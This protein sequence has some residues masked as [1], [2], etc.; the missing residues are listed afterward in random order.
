MRCAVMAGGG[1]VSAVEWLGMADRPV[2][3]CPGTGV[4]GV[5]C[6]STAFVCGAESL[7]VRPYFGCGAHVP[8]CGEDGGVGGGSGRGRPVVSACGVA[9]WGGLPGAVR[10]VLE[11]LGEPVVPAGVRLIGATD[12][13]WGDEWRL[14]DD[15]VLWRVGSAPGGWTSMRLEEFEEVFPAVWGRHLERLGAC[16]PV[17]ARAVALA[18]ACGADPSEG[19]VVLDAW[20]RWCEVRL[21]SPL[22]GRLRVLVP[23]EGPLGVRSGW[24]PWVDGLDEDG[25]LALVRRAA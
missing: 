9:G 16:G 20:G 15:E 18:V 24:G 12:V 22:G 14:F 5:A 23:Q 7:V 2:V 17:C 8:G 19:P 6:S 21:S 11:V 25:A 1:S 4:D 3:R 10:R 13:R